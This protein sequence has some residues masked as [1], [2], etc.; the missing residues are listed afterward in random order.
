MSD[1]FRDKVAI[2]GMGCARFGERWEMDARDL[3]IEAVD[4]AIK[5]AGVKLTDMQ[6]VWVGN[7]NDLGGASLVSE[8]LKMHDKPVTRC[9]NWCS[10][11]IDAF[12]NACYGVASGV[13]DHV[14][15]VGYEK[16]KDTGARGLPPIGVGRGGHPFLLHGMS[17]PSVLALAA[18][19]YFYKYG[20]DKSTLAKVAVK[21]HHNGSMNPKAFLR[22]EVTLEQVMNAPIISWPLGLFDCCGIADG[23]AAAV[24]VRSD[25]AKKY[26]DDYVMVKGVGLAISAMDPQYRP[27]AEW[28]GFTATQEAT[29]QAYEQAGIEEPRKEINVIECH[30]CFTIAE[31]IA[32]EDLGFAKPGEGWKLIEDGVTS[33]KG[34][35]PVNMDGGLKSFG[36]PIGASGVRMLYEIYKQIQGKCGERQVPNVKMGV[37]HNLGGNP[38]AAGVAVIGASK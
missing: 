34:D 9:E 23:A 20:I 31:I 33:L 11:G 2:V 27:S 17:A 3:I 4:E 28:T 29:R 35:L 37:A 1:G 13:F 8:A 7:Q 19:R 25:L 38:T 30:D 32:T 21:N 26:R 15:V 36:H 18:T 22:A 16:L 5:D 14:L 12:R 10:S 6:A 24:I